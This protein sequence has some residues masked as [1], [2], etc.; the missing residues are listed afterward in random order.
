MGGSRIVHR[1]PVNPPPLLDFLP[2]NPKLQ[3][4]KLYYRSDEYSVQNQIKTTL[5]S[6]AVCHHAVVLATRLW[7][8]KMGVVFFSA[9]AHPSSESPPWGILDPPLTRV[10]NAC[11]QRMHATFSDKYGWL[12]FLAYVIPIATYIP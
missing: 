2:M 6:L 5:S 7:V 9:H 1:V 10:S 8:W 4:N 12:N 3:I 11:I